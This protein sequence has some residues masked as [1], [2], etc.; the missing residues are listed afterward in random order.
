MTAKRQIL[1]SL[2]PKAGRCSSARRA[3]EL[4]GR[5]AALGYTVELLTDLN[6]VEEKAHRLFRAGELRALV[7]VGGD[8]TAAEL[9]RRTPPGTPITLLPAG[10]ANLLAKE[11][12]LPFDPARAAAMIDAGRTVALDAASAGGRLFLIMLTAGIDAE[13]VAQVHR[14]REEKF[15][16]GTGSRG[17]IGYRSYLGPVLRSIRRYPYPAIQVEP[18][19]TDPGTESPPVRWAFLFNIPRYGFGAATATGSDPQDALLD[20]C[21]FRRGGLFPSLFG[22]A[23]ASLGKT[24]RF[25]PGFRFQKST[26]FRL[27]PQ[28]ADTQ[29]PYQIDG[30]PV[31]HLPAE[32][33]ILPRR[34][35][36]LVPKQEAARRA[37]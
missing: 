34:F 16:S 36:L 24:H 4:R 13:I 26:R 1:I 14:N 8:G 19:E 27:A 10:T 22:I 30:D 18:A 35:T 29:I 21:G 7:G 11:F 15:R 20:F 31:G 9:V 3:E 12:R 28:D 33:R 23:L 25:F 2:N 37:G 6:E 5:L 17:H 32:I